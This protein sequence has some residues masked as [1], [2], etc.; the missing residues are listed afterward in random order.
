MNTKLFALAALALSITACLQDELADDIRLPEGKYPLVI[1]SAALQTG[2][3][4][5]ATVDG[6][7]STGERVALKVDGDDATYTYTVENS[8]GAMSGNYYWQTTAPITV[9]GFYPY[10]AAAAAEWE[11]HSSQDIEENYY[12]SDLLVSPK[13]QITWEGKDNASLDFCHQTAKV[14]MNIVN[15]EFVASIGNAFDVTIN[16][17]VLSG[18][19]NP[20]AS[21]SYGTWNTDGRQ[22]SAITPHTAA[23]TD[24]Y[25]ATFEALVIPQT[26]SNGTDLFIFNV[27]GYDPFIYVPGGDIEWKPGYE[28]TYTVT[29]AATGLS[30]SVAESSIGWNTAGNTGTGSVIMPGIREVGVNQY[31]VWDAAGLD[32]WA[33]LVRRGNSNASCKLLADIAYDS[34]KEW[35]PIGNGELL[36]SGTFDGNG[37]T[38]SNITITAVYEYYGLFG[39]VN[40]GGTIKN[41][42]VKNMT[43][44]STSAF[45][46]IGGIAG[47]STGTIEGCTIMGSKIGGAGYPSDVGGIAGGLHYGRIYRCQIT[48]ST[49]E[50]TRRIGGIV[51][52]N[53]SSTE[54]K[55][56]SFE[57]SIAHV[58]GLESVPNMGGIAGISRS[59]VT[60]CWAACQLSYPTQQ[61]FSDYVGGV[62]G[63]NTDTI[64]ACYWQSDDISKGVGKGTD[65]T[66]RVSTWQEAVEGMNA[67]LTGYDWRW[68]LL[69]GNTY[70]TLVQNN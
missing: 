1:R 51:G 62:V 36:Y 10:E 29:I 3:S 61:Y 8:Q 22:A 40:D 56:C 67:A 66:T 39:R 49:I 24:G 20:P 30:V 68:E 17:V 26:I 27:D 64:T 43:V 70:P 42:N 21:G 11:V 31:E 52:D 25:A 16:G 48:G 35:V 55:A 13:E 5:S 46:Y 57:G 4:T 18:T 33:D 59:A 54:V 28:Y 60:A 47:S 32:I 2:I 63:N 45:A 9:Q 23:T 19:F 41:L 65:N 50:G 38:I 58:G 37:K 69:D 44:T 6:T 12:G 15:D 34:P 7:W 14:V 53:S